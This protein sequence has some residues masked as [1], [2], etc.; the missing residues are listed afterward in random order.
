MIGEKLIGVLVALALLPAA[1]AA[2]AAAP[3]PITS[4]F[5][6]NVYSQPRLS[7]DGKYLAVI[8]PDAEHPDRRAVDVFD[9]KAM[10]L[11]RSFRP[12]NA[13][14]SVNIQLPLDLY[15]VSDKLLMFTTGFDNGN[16]SSAAAMGHIYVVDVEAAR[17]S[18]GHGEWTLTNYEILRI[19]PG[20]FN[21]VTVAFYP[22]N[23]PIVVRAL[24]FK[25]EYWWDG[26]TQSPFEN[27]YLMA[28]HA[29][30]PRL[31]IAFDKFSGDPKW[32]IRD[33]ERHWQRLPAGL[34]AQLNTGPIDF[35]SDDRGL[36]LYEYGDAGGGSPMLGLYKYD[37]ASGKQTLLYADKN[38]DVD[39]V[40]FGPR[41][42]QIVAAVVMDGRPRLM[43]LDQ[44]GIAAKVLKTAAANFPGET[45]RV[46][47]WTQDASRAIVRVSGGRN[48]GAYYLVDTKTLRMTLLLRSMPAIAVAAMAPVQ[49]IAFR[50]RDDVLIHGYLTLPNGVE[51]RNLPLVVDVHDGPNGRDRWAFDPMAQ[52]L[53]SRGYAVLQ[54]NYRGSFGYGRSFLASGFG[55][56]GTTMQQD[57]I[58]ATRW[59]IGQ[60]IAD[61]ERICIF[62][63]GFGGYTAI[64]SSEL[65]PELY[66]CAVAYDGIYDLP[67]F[68]K[69][70]AATWYNNGF[71]YRSFDVRHFR[72]MKKILGSDMQ[73]LNDQSPVHHVDKLRN[74]IF[75]IHGGK[76]W[77]SPVGQVEAMK[78][79]LDKAH[80][81]YE[82]LYKPHEGLGYSKI[83]DQRELAGKLLSFLNRYIGAGTA[84]DGANV[85][86]N[87]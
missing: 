15:W 52:L 11:F 24:R 32:K 5:T 19:N 37:P 23:H 48:P 4:L 67:A 10:K 36:Y 80:K 35:T 12:N 87:H 59:A 72:Y 79:A 46:V 74:A 13:V 65:A 54:V 25:P 7:P 73:A 40:M 41:G 63:V 30:E 22:V 75:L 20:K 34:L 78:A 29:G 55:H 66:Q 16:F 86:I 21:P 77:W 71:Y 68:A 42:K 26:L 33:K 14:G 81:D 57:I 84:D 9:L 69:H 8:G 6:E 18:E 28:D 1:G 17:R 70:D 47:S 2:G 43:L 27:G 64:R 76:D 51:P 82:Y 58:D 45:P 38:N 3:V 56:W 53:A 62:G 61:P 31:A 39:S 50:S 49:P 44:D 83:E 85:V 60:H